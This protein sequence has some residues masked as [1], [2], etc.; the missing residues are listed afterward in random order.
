MDRK[1]TFGDAF[2]K[3][4]QAQQKLEQERKNLKRKLAQLKAEEKQQG[5][6]RRLLDEAAERACHMSMMAHT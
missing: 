4:E 2:E 3:V 5:Q 1:R 6:R